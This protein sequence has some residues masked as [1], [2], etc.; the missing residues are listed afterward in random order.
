[1]EIFIIVLVCHAQYHYR[2][3][4]FLLFFCMGPLIS[5]QTL[6]LRTELTSTCVK[7]DN[8]L[9]GKQI[10]NLFLLGRTWGFLKYYH[11]VAEDNYFQGSLLHI[12]RHS[13]YDHFVVCIAGGWTHLVVFF[14]K[15]V[16][17]LIFLGKFSCAAAA[18]HTAF[19]MLLYYSTGKVTIIS[20]CQLYSSGWIGWKY[21]SVYNAG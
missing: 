11:P 2:H 4:F 1:M 18:H 17:K 13:S 3:L 19:Y 7:I 15:C 9:S 6:N 21:G 12:G 10:E 16:A 8:P 20:F 5:S 14:P